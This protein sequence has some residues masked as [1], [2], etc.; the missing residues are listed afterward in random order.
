MAPPGAEVLNGS[1]S[2]AHGPSL[3]LP[4]GNDAI[5]MGAL[6]LTSQGDTEHS[7]AASGPAKR[8]LGRDDAGDQGAS[9]SQALS[10]HQQNDNPTDTP[11][12][13]VRHGTGN[14]WTRATTTKDRLPPP[15]FAIPP[16][17]A[18]TLTPAQQT[19]EIANVD[20]PPTDLDNPFIDVTAGPTHV[21]GRPAP[22]QDAQSVFSKLRSALVLSSAPTDPKPT[23]KLGPLM[24][25]TATPLEG[26]PE[27]HL[28]HATCLFDRQDPAQAEEWATSNEDAALAS[29]FDFNSK[30]PEEIACTG[31]E[32]AIIL[33]QLT[34]HNDLEVGIPIKKEPERDANGQAIRAPWFD[35]APLRMYLIYDT[36][37]ASLEDLAKQRIWSFKNI[38]FE[39]RM[40]D[41]SFP[42]PTFLMSFTAAGFRKKDPAL[43]KEV[44]HEAWNKN[45]EVIM[46]EYTTLRQPGTTQKD[47]FHMTPDTL[48][49]FLRTVTQKM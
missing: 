4:N 28:E 21:Q 2:A 7:P 44:I 22:H 29:I 30:S 46:D 36:P 18:L 34:E 32:L 9:K 33:R 26:W 39:V 10:R 8:Q 15:T 37:K 17:A 1:D 43:V 25:Y 40:V 16:N 31:Q 41:R 13:P 6:S 5:T 12:T 24:E 42:H 20:Q 14:P 35:V 49:A 3:I 47:I 27:V 19:T 48:H 38:T 11:Q 45:R 23:A